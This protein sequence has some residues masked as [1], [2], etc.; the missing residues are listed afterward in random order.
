MYSNLISRIQSHMLVKLGTLAGL[1]ICQ[2]RFVRLSA[3]LTSGCKVRCLSG[4]FER[5]TCRW[6]G[7]STWATAARGAAICIL[8]FR[9]RH[10]GWANVSSSQPPGRII[11]SLR[12]ERDVSHQSPNHQV[13]Q[14]ERLCHGH[15][16]RPACRIKW[17]GNKRPRSVEKGLFETGVLQNSVGCDNLTAVG[18]DL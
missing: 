15:Q 11:A 2:H 5:S 13:G 12:H 4:G 8:R 7:L 1:D 3:G 9:S 10:A 17:D 6:S 16:K 18:L 14:I